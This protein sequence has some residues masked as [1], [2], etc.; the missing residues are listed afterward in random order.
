MRRWL[1]CFILLS[2]ML[3]AACGD[4]RTTDA[5][6][7]TKA[8]LERPGLVIRSDEEH[9]LRQFGGPHLPV[10]EEIELEPGAQAPASGS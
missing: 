10:A 8:P 1:A 7:Y 2:L 3:V 9:D 4:P 5:R 6:G